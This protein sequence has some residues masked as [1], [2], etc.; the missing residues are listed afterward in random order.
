MSHGILCYCD[1]CDA[2]WAA[3]EAELVEINLRTVVADM[4]HRNVMNGLWAAAFYGTLTRLYPGFGLGLESAAPIEVRGSAPCSRCGLR[5]GP[6][7]L[8]YTCVDEVAD[9]GEK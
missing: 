5:A 1:E 8:C 3:E 7:G 9:G 4:E 2:S 6:S